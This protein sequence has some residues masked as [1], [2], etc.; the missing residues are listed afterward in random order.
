M[1]N[2]VVVI[3]EIFS[4]II[5][6]IG[7]VFVLYFTFYCT[8]FLSVKANS[9]QKSKYI[10]IIDKAVLGQNKYLAIAEIKNKYYLLSISDQSIN[11][12]K[13]LND[14]EHDNH[15]NIYQN[16]NINLDFNK[17]FSKIS[18]SINKKGNEIKDDKQSK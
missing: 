11:I 17:I 13:E 12:L 8:K 1:G 3:K 5:S 4:V 7:I 9:I 16:A 6:I 14:F 18:D 2:K 10:N 15:E